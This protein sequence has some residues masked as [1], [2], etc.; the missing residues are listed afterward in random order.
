V[1][2][3]AVDH[4]LE[5]LEG[6]RLYAVTASAAGGILTVL[7]DSGSNVITVSRNAAGNLLVNNGAVAISGPAATVAG[8]TAIHVLGGS[9]HDRITIDETA[10]AMPKAS[11]SG[12]SGN[13]AL[14]GGAGNDT[15]NGDGGNDVLLGLGGADQLNGGDG[16]DILT[17]GAGTDQAFGQA[18][19]D[20]MI[21]NPGDGSDLNEGG[22]GVDTVEVI[23]GGVTEAFSAE[24][25]GD[26]VLFRRID[27]APF[28]ID[29]G[30]TEKL[31]LK[32][33]AGDDSFFGGT[34]LAGRTAFTVD[35]GTGNDTI[36]GT[37][38]A[39]RLIGGDGDDFIDGNAG[40][41][42]ALMGA[43]NDVFR[44]DPGDGSDTV[45]GQSGVDRM[46]FNGA[47]ADEKIDLSANG[48]RLRF[49]RD[50]GNI[51][52]DTN[53]V[54]VVDFNAAGGADQV[55]V[56]SLKGTD[57]RAV[58]VSLSPPG[59]ALG[60]GLSQSVIVE[61]TSGNDLVSVTGN[62]ERGVIVAG[63][64]ALVTVTGTDPLDRLTVKSFAGN[65]I[66]SAAT[67][68]A[69]AMLFRTEGGDGNDLLVGGAGNDTLLGGNDS[70]IIIGAAGI[71]LLDGGPGI[72]VILQ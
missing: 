40:A 25:V 34:G 42:L 64:S 29:V 48:N 57:V 9:G 69:D 38:G 72:D 44:W 7:G 35:G 10:G 20:R 2:T 21:W 22:D 63:L 53:D 39:D 17:G 50:A 26:R 8:I 32:A 70:D 13:D 62:A 16:N 56:H 14:T 49:F 68:D 28:T 4:A 6:R 51:T 31:L 54:E 60:D 33:G 5:P 59:A 12:G 23:G 45:E 37:D 65:D 36:V 41:D 71:D 1:L 66:V 52:M 27:P 61:G 24:G 43:G 30:G 46:L 67:L 18:G 19:D 11:L 58:N 47:K 3:R 15:L 55:T